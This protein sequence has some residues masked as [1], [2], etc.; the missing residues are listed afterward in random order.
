MSPQEDPP[1]CWGD[2]LRC[3]TGFTFTAVSPSLNSG[4]RILTIVSDMALKGTEE[5]L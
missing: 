2:K 5:E 3:F 1:T 4:L